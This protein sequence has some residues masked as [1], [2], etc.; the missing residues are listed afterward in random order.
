[1]LWFESNDLHRHSRVTPSLLERSR[2]RAS[3]RAARAQLPPQVRHAAAQAIARHLARQS[4]LRPGLRIALYVSLREEIDT[5]PLM[6]MLE[7]RGCHV[8][9]P[10]VENARVGRMRLV[11]PTRGFRRGAFG[12]IE[13][14]GHDSLGARWCRAILLPTLGID[15]RGVRLGY[16]AGF[17]DR[18]LAFRHVR[19]EWRGPELIAL[20]FSVQMADRIPATRHDVRVDAILTERGLQPTLRS[21]R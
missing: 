21:A 13:P 4:W 9:L 20:A 12:I 17:Y 10:R 1:M 15:A 8:Y 2:L 7:R 16:G 11:R 18:M 5:T 19:R 3:L 6:R 14:L